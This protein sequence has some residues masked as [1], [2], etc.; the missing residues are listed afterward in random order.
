MQD[1]GAQV[2]AAVKSLR[3][4]ASATLEACSGYSDVHLDLIALAMRAACELES[5]CKWLYELPYSLAACTAQEDAVE[6]LRQYALAEPEAHHP[7]TKE[8]FQGSCFDAVEHLSRTGESS[9]VLSAARSRIRRYPLS[10]NAA[11]GGHRD[12]TLAKRTWHRYT[13]PYLLSTGRRRFNFRFLAHRFKAGDGRARTRE[14]DQD[15]RNHRTLVKSKFHKPR[16]GRRQRCRESYLETLYRTADSFRQQYPTLENAFA[17]SPTLPSDDTAAGDE[18]HRDYAKAVFEERG[19]YSYPRPGVEE[20]DGI[21]W[22]DANVCIYVVEIISR[23]KQ[24]VKSAW[25]R[26]RTSGSVDLRIQE[27]QV[28]NS[29]RAT[30]T[31]PLDVY[32]MDIPE[33]LDAMTCWPFQVMT[34]KLRRLV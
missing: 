6:A 2:A 3:K 1:A 18:T 5:K 24:Y 32:F 30:D 21:T 33:V 10:E 9:A 17:R 16:E 22:A 8:F 31:T 29:P 26:R 20:E 13:L 14:F 34:K 25:A 7:L 4:L 19:V 23:S 27:L 11:E 15:W 28:W 12:M